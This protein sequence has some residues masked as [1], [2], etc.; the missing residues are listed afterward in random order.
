MLSIGVLSVL[1]CSLTIRGGLSVLHLGGIGIGL[2][3]SSV[4]SLSSILGLDIVLSLYS[5][6]FLG[7]L[8]RSLSVLHLSRVDISLLSSGVLGLCSVG[9]LGVLGSCLGI[10]QLGSIG[11][12][13]L[14]GGSLG[15]YGLIISRLQMLE[16][17]L[18]RQWHWPSC[19]L[20]D[21]SGGEEDG[22]D[23]E[24]HSCWRLVLS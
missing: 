17:V 23:L 10:L 2:L 3:L 13:L 21:G 16:A 8:S 11:I 20:R 9:L 18:E 22:G 15:L 12:C 6:G 4:L 7:V 14:R 5:I 1:C 19:D 24:L